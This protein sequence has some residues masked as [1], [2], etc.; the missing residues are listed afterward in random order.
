MLIKRVGPVSCAK[1]LGVIYAIFGLVAGV[2][3]SLISL[4]GT[5][6]PNSRLPGGGLFG[7]FAIVLMPITYG[8]VGFISALIGAW[9]YNVLA[10]LVGGIE[11]D[12]E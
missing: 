3:F 4:A 6:A 1:I 9:L 10:G 11:M 7:T 12:V 5:F 2:I 8:I